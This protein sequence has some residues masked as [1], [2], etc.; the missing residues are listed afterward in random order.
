MVARAG[1]V[2]R[3]RIRAL[4]PPA[5]ALAVALLAGGC[6]GRGELRRPAPETLPPDSPLLSATLTDGDA[7]L[8]HHLMAGEYERALELLDH[9]AVSRGD[10]V[11]RDLQ[12]GLLLHHAGRY[13]L[14]N[15]AFARAEA[16]IERRYTLSVSRGLLA[17]GVND[18]RLA[19]TAPPSERALLPFYR[20]LN[21]LAL[22]DLE[23]AAVEASKA[24][25]RSAAGRS[26]AAA[27]CGETGML[28][29][30]AGT[31]QTAVAEENDAL[32]SLRQA[33]AAFDGCDGMIAAGPPSSLGLDL[34]LAA[35]QAGVTEIAES[36]RARYGL[37]EVALSGG[38]L[39]V[40]VEEGFV[41]HRSPEALHVPIFPEEIEGLEGSDGDAV[42]AAA[43]RVA[44]RLL[45]N[46]A[47]RSL[48]GR[49][50]DDIQWVQWANALSGAYV[51]RLAWP[52][53]RYEPLA[54]ARVRVV[55][56]DEPHPLM[57]VGEI[58]PLVEDDLDA[59]RPAM[60]ARLITRGMVKYITA[61]EVEKM[62]EGESEVGGFFAGRI[63]NLIANEL[64]RADTRS[65][66][67]LPDRVSIAR[68]RLPAGRHRVRI[69]TLGPEGELLRSLDLGEV[70][71]VEGG[72]VAISERV[73]GN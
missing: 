53:T 8:R 70:E 13:E 1:G 38:S 62:V 25:A 58:S 43:A 6:A 48:W 22:G 52:V 34:H 60:L 31:V 32:V 19:Y 63:V 7:W 27:G 35:R 14:S 23:G 11:I 17:V 65:W 64:E 56:G 29:Y 2:R 24:N 50:Y 39:L 12:A 5:L 16:E 51:M 55:I 20:M 10:E 57:P 59:Q 3:A 46:A 44:A 40:V 9:P 33:E 54:P 68:F 45:E 26:G 69:E 37:G 71:V 49:S 72:L 15:R 61:R 73:W 18:G 47:E 42:A 4:R 66:S 67:L 36:T 21:H 41:S 28:A 30:L